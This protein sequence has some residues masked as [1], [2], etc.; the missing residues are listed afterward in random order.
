MIKIFNWA[1]R[2]C[3]SFFIWWKHFF[4]GIKILLFDLTMIFY[5]QP[6]YIQ[7]GPQIS[8]TYVDVDIFEQWTFRMKIWN[9]PE[10]R[11][12][13]LKHQNK[14]KVF[15]K[16]LIAKMI[17]MISSNNA[18]IIKFSQSHRKIF[19]HRKNQFFICFN[20]SS[21]FDVC[22]IRRNYVLIIQSQ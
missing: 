18:K 20:F 14:T 2:F 1:W 8:T 17:Q 6:V 19:K 15:E 11:R 7:S 10:S 13:S 21:I 9:H 3:N 5:G 12:L 16:V 4:K 22:P